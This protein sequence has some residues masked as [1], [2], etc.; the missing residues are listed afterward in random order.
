MQVNS[1]SRKLKLVRAASPL[2]VGPI[3][4]SRAISSTNSPEAR[5][6]PTAFSNRSPGIRRLRITTSLRPSK[7][8]LVAPISRAKVVVLMPP[9]VPPGLA[10]MN[11]STITSSSPASETVST[12]RGTVLK[13]AV[14]V[15]IDWNRVTCRR[16]HS[17][18]SCTTPPTAKYSVNSNPRVPIRISSTVLRSTRRVCRL[19]RRMRANRKRL[20]HTSLITRQPM[21]PITIIEAI[22]PFTTG[23]SR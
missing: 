21:P 10:P 2:A 16:C 5:A 11:I 18:S 9:P 3:P 8:D 4:S 19:S 17:D 1:F 12:D 22:T 14:R 7:V 23:L 20:A 6:T 15:V 13:P